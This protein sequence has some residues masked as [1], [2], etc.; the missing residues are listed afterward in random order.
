MCN[1]P[2]ETTFTLQKFFI[3]N[4]KE[5]LIIDQ[6]GTSSFS[7]IITNALILARSI[8]SNIGKNKRI[9]VPAFHSV[10]FVESLLAVMF[11]GNICIPV[12][13]HLTPEQL[14]KIVWKFKIDDVIDQSFSGTE[15]GNI[16]L[17]EIIPEDIAIALLTSGS[18][19]EPKAVALTQQNIFSNALSVI[20]SMKLENPGKVAIILPLYH[21]FALVT[22]LITT[23]ITGG[24]IYM[25][26]EFKFPGELINFIRDN[27]IETIAGVPTNFKLLLM[28][29]ELIFESVK[30][31]TIAGSSL[32]PGFAENIKKAF[33]NSEI[34]VGYGLTEAGP[35]VTAINDSEPQFKLGAVGRPVDRVQVKIN[36]HEVIVK[37]PSIMKEYLDDP[38]TTSEKI[39]NKWLHTGDLGFLDQEGY[40]YIKGRKDDIFSSGGEKISPLTIE[41]IINKYPEVHSSAV[42][43]E[44]DSILGNKIIAL[45]Q[46]KE[47]K[48]LRPKDLLEHCRK[49]LENYFVP[50]K[51]FKVTSL[52][53][54][55]NGKLQRKELPKCPKEKF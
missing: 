40:L 35:R 51:F 41:R 17:P 37:G 31:I 38:L 36:N 33:P 32:D 12:N 22:Q 30:H 6:Y 50:H 21:S 18:T 29:N 28:G 8:Y 49:Y 23:L 52:P 55:P 5:S 27:N 48:L 43:G 15:T 2:D 44:E 1:F 53:L 45:V 4:K 16:S 42:Y 34:W 13:P 25:V 47:G 54:T 24:S 39:T 46:L 11:S 26:P 3:E 7:E 14:K 19:G 20:K 10:R 9:A